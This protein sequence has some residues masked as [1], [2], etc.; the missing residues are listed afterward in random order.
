MVIADAI[1][2]L[3]MGFCGGTYEYIFAHTTVRGNISDDAEQ[4]EIDA[5]V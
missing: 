4:N 3:Q 2:Y 5:A 1:L